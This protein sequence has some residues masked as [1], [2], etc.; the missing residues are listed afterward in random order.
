LTAC[1]VKPWLT[2]GTA[3]IPLTNPLT[4]G[5]TFTASITVSGLG[6]GE[7][8]YYTIGSYTS[9]TYTSDGTYTVTYQLPWTEASSAGNMV[10]Y[11][12]SL[13][14]SAFTISNISVVP[15][16]V[17]GTLSTTA[18]SQGNVA[19]YVPAVASDDFYQA[20]IKTGAIVS[21]SGT[22]A[23]DF[24]NGGG[25]FIALITSSYAPNKGATT[26]YDD[27]AVQLDLKTGVG[28]LPPIQQ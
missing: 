10:F 8:V 22:T 13:I 1:T 20:V 17:N 15:S 21:P 6:S 11:S 2:P 5:T 16:V 12:S 7:S 19:S 3:T 4:A 28:F 18:D 23:V 27:F 14:D 24:S 26:F 9:P 25:D